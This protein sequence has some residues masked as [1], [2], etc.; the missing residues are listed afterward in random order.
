ME[1]KIK[2]LSPDAIIPTKA[3]FNDAGFDLYALEDYELRTLKP[4]L[5]STGIAMEI[6]MGFFGSIRDRSGLGSK[7]IHVLAGIVDSSYRGE[8]KVAL[9]LLHADIQ[10]TYDGKP[11]LE[12]SQEYPLCMSRQYHIKKG[13][14]IAQM[15]IQPC[16]LPDLIEVPE[17]TPSNRGE[18]GFGSTGK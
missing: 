2:K 7:G 6:P 11:E 17:L 15:I 5:I 18:G 14:R 8:V 4:M 1:L 16:E 9:V 13:D 12:N 10:W 3:Y